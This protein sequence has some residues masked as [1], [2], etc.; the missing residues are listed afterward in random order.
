LGEAVV[1]D[2]HL[3]AV[4]AIFDAR[5]ICMDATGEI[6][7]IARALATLGMRDAARALIDASNAIDEATEKASLAFSASVNQ[8]VIDTDQA[9]GNMIAAFI[10]GAKVKDTPLSEPHGDVVNAPRRSL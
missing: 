6:D 4:N 10:A 8:R 9:T 2:A 1:S 7:R 5:C 3:E